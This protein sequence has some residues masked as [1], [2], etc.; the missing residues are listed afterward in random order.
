MSPDEQTLS[1][2]PRFSW[3]MRKVPRPDGKGY[4]IE[5]ASEV[6]EWSHYH[7]TIPDSIPNNISKMTR[8][9]VPKAHLYGRARDFARVLKPSYLR[10]R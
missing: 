8:A 2:R 1:R 7:E 5:Y 10:L 3:D 9:M 6:R 4:Q